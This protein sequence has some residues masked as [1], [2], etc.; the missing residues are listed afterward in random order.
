MMVLQVVQLKNILLKEKGSVRAG[1]QFRAMHSWVGPGAV[2]E[3]MICYV[4]LQSRFE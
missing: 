3:F 4:L 1:A 2:G